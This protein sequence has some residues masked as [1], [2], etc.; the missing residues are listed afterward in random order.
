MWLHL[1]DYDNMAK[2]KRKRLSLNGKFKTIID[3]ESDAKGMQY[4]KNIHYWEYW[5]S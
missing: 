1:F 5:F 4:K 2:R 3:G